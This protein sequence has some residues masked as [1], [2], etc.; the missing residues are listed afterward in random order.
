LPLYEYRC[1]KCGTLIEK[2]QKFSDKPLTKC[3]KCGGRLERVLSAPAIK[4]KGSGWYINDYPRKSSGESSKS[5]GES[6]A[7]TDSS[8]S[9]AK[10]SE[11][12]A[13]KKPADTSPATKK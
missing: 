2:I 12:P 13:A 4:F 11:S 8:T 10:K 9:A 3:G 6:S 1:Q 7:R 5:D